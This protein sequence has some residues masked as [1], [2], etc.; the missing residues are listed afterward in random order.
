MILPDGFATEPAGSEW[1]ERLMKSLRE[2]LPL[3]DH[4]TRH[5]L[6]LT[7]RHLIKGGLG[8]GILA[9]SASGLTRLADAAPAP[10]GG[11]RGGTSPDKCN[12][13]VPAAVGGPMPADRN[14]ISL[15]WLGCACFELVYRN[16][17]ILLDAWYD[18]PLCRDIGMAPQEVKRAN[19]I[20]IGHAHFDHIADATSIAKRTGATVIADAVV[21]SGFLLAQG[22]PAKQI[23]AVNGLAGELLRFNG[24][25]V[26]PILAQHSISPA[27]VNAEGE[28]AGQEITDAY[29]AL[30]PPLSST[31]LEAAATVFARGSADPQIDTQG[32]IAYL[33]TFDSGYQLMWLDSAGAITPAL[34]AAMAKIKS[35]NLAIV[36]YQAQALARFQVPVTM[37]LVELFNPD[38]FFPAH[39]DE[40]LTS[41]DGKSLF[42][43]S[44]DMATEPLVL[45]IR[46]T[47]PKTHPVSALYRT[48]V[49]VDIRT[50]KFEI[51]DACEF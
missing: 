1:E 4:C 36:G 32:T 23:R 16:Q 18:R 30:L 47:L 37:Q 28:R 7:R 29:L 21:G 48:P 43:V 44:P 3:L 13:L 27:S 51:G 31:D 19:L 9:A 24:F 14:V 10:G 38:L 22:L 2:I 33:F 50:G 34:R 11:W 49:F 41:A 8:G 17:V 20:V 15:R 35:V 26:Q 6:E 40:L 25:T 39:H 42:F 5:S 46:E 45:A 12:N